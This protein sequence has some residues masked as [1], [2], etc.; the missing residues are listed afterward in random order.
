[1][2]DEPAAAF[3]A[4]ILSVRTPDE[5]NRFLHESR[6]QPTTRKRSVTWLWLVVLLFPLPF[7][8]WWLGLTCLAV[9]VFLVCM[10]ARDR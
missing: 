5:Q 10:L 9:F 3:M 6:F 4:Y 1:M 7:S 2:T 8:P